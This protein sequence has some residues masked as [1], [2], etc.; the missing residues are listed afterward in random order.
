MNICYTS[1]PI[2]IFNEIY[3][4]VYASM[5]I[6]NQNEQLLTLK[7]I[8]IKRMKQPSLSFVR[9]IQLEKTKSQLE[10]VSASMYP[11]SRIHGLGRKMYR[12]HGVQHFCALSFHSSLGS[13]SGVHTPEILLCLLLPFL[14]LMSSYNNAYAP[15][16]NLLFSFCNHGPCFFIKKGNVV[17]IC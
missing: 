8:L 16:S 15:L 17:I 1:K 14:V 5:T 11:L 6:S 12:I 13:P 3:F 10:L 7:S 2:I 9:N 4:F